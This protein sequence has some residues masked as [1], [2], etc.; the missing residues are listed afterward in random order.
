VPSPGVERVR[1]LYHVKKG[2]T[3]LSIARAYRTSVNALQS[4]NRI[5]GSQI[6]AGERITIYAS[7]SR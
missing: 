1:I 2:D 4:W 3:L 7:R 5:P 6:R